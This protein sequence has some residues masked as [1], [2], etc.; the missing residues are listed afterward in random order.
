MEFIEEILELL[1]S[2]GSALYLGEAVT[3]RE[4]A[5][6]SAQLAATSGAADA[7]I[8]AALLHDIAYLIRADTGHHEEEGSRW[9][10]QY[11]GPEVTEPVRLHVAAKRYLCTVS[12][13]YQQ[14]LSSAS[15][16]SL[17]RQGGL[18]KTEELRDFETSR[19]HA[20]AIQLRTWDDCAKVP[21]LAVPGPERYLSILLRISKQLGNRIE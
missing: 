5:L 8:T 3:Q 16:L 14:L 21:H 19:F 6:Q 12:P 9:L 4:H 18:L 7:L 13:S 20:D 2:R 11:F 1:S 17:E 15:I 10:S